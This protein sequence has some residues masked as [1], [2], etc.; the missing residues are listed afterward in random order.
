MLVSYLGI[1]R[2]DFVNDNNERVTG[3]TLYYGYPTEGVDG[4]FPNKSTLKPTMEL[5]AGIK[6]G[7]KLEVDFSPQGKIVSIS[8][9]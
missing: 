9:A 4:I 5:P 1:R 6:A 8:K 2:Y 7:D 3:R